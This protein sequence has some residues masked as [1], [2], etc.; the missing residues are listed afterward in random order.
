M[1]FNGVNKRCAGCNQECKCWKQVS[2]IICPN[3]QPNRINAK[4]AFRLSTK[5]LKIAPNQG[6]F[7]ASKGKLP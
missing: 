4:S 1:P 2:V 3:Y 5:L 7:Q 6:V